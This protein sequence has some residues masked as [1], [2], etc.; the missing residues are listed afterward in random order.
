MWMTGGNNDA[1]VGCKLDGLAPVSA[2]DSSLRKIYRGVGGVR[3]Y[4]P[5]ISKL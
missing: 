2:I 5:N 1:L 4:E 3:G